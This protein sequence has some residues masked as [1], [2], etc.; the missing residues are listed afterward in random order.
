LAARASQRAPF[1]ARGW[2][3]EQLIQRRGTCPV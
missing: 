1:L 3:L 2:E